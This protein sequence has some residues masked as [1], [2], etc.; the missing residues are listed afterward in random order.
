M[1]KRGALDG[2]PSPDALVLVDELG[3]VVDANDLAVELLGRPREQ[4]VGSEAAVVVPLQ[5][6][7]G[8][9]VW[10]RGPVDAAHLHLR[11]FLL[12]D[13]HGG[14][15]AVQ[16][17]AADLE[18]EGD[19]PRGV[20]LSLR[21][22]RDA[23]D[24]MEVV[25]TVSHELRSPL[26]AVKGYTSLLLNRWTRLEDEQKRFMLEQ[27]HHD[28]DRVTRLVTE[29]LDISRLETGRL[30]L[31]PQLVS[32]PEVAESVVAKVRMEYPDLECS[33]DFPN[34]FPEVLADP[35][36]IEQVVTNLVENAAKYASPVGMRVLGRHV[37]GSITV[38][39]H[40]KGEGIPADDLPRVFERFFRAGHNKPSGTGLGLWISRG[41]VEA[42]GGRITA[43]STPGK[44][45]T[46]AFTLPMKPV[47]ASTS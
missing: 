18:P 10:T 12:P 45:S 40:D 36:K 41:L 8:R 4:L 27:I 42:H 11:S 15:M 28:A 19:E 16:A 3:F 22:E 32:L 34:A 33:F 47:P 31:H 9:P 37:D 6:T 17:A 7:T 39:V 35:D 25:A 1:T 29:L 23:A 24:A 38:E 14:T 30:T 44:G 43:D 13:G 2:V 26:T 5:S 46:F 21:R 20:V